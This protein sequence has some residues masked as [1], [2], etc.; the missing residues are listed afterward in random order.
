M[1]WIETLQKLVPW[2][3]GLPI[4]PKIA[5][6]GIVFIIAALL[7][8]MIWTPRPTIAPAEDPSVVEAFERMKRVLLP[9]KQLDD[10]KIMVGDEQVS[11][12][13]EQYYLDY[14]A[15][16]NYIRDHPEDIEGTYEVIWEHGGANR[17]FINDTNAFETVVSAF[18]ETYE[19]AKSGK[20]EQ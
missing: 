19:R 1:D 6:S 13:L 11:K 10:G 17:A 9:L 8:L 12:K 16:A 20:G 14:V 4:V 7:L 5:I 18:F 15:I 2:V 3:S